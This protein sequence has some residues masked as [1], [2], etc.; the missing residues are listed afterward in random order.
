MRMFTPSGGVA[1]RAA[2]LPGWTVARRAVAMQG[3]AVRAGGGGRAVG[4]QAQGPAPA[5]DDG[6]VV[7]GAQGD[8]VGQD[9]GA[10]RRAGDEVMDLAA[11]GGLL[12]TGEGAA[13]MAGGHGAAE[14]GGDGRFGLAG[15]QRD[16]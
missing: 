4:M 1:G 16:G 7:K 9:G 2:V 14:M 6:Q 10:A 5:V 15:V 8:Q 12:A 11:A 3:P 13:R